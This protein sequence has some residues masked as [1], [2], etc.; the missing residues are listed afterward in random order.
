MGSEEADMALSAQSTD[1][2]GREVRA[3]DG[4]RLGKVRALGADYLII[5]RGLHFPE[6]CQVP[7]VDIA[8]STETELHLLRPGTAYLGGPIVLGAGDAAFGHSE[9]QDDGQMLG[10]DALDEQRA[11]IPNTHGSDDLFE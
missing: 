11:I 4:V 7:F 8:S 2:V 5:E 9:Q 1:L 6:G 10:D 3:S